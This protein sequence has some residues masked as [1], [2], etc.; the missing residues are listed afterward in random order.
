MARQQHK[1]RNLPANLRKFLASV[2]PAFMMVLL[3]KNILQ[4]VEQVSIITY[5]PAI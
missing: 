5:L 2:S 3:S 4:I 1:C